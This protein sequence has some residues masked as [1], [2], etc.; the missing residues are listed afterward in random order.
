[1]EGYYS[2]ELYSILDEL[3]AGIE[4]IF[5]ELTDK[6]K[7]EIMISKL[8]EKTEDLVNDLEHEIEKLEIIEVE[9]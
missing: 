8:R 3:N 5:N 6:G 4:D 1:M 7:I 9:A 2:D